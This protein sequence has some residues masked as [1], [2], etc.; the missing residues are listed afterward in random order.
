MNSI[1]TI[2]ALSDLNRLRVMWLLD[3]FDELCVCQITEVLG[4]ATPTVSKHMSILYSAGLVKSRKESRWVYYRL[5]EIYL[6]NS[7]LQNF[8][9]WSIK[10]NEDQ[11]SEDITKVDSCITVLKEES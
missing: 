3:K 10:G 11:V 5:G 7:E 4:L 9:S 1:Q 8:I 6:Q 2:K